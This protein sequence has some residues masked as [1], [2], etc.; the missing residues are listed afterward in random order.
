M[1]EYVVGLEELDESAIARAGGKAAHLGALTRIEGIRVPAGFCVTTEAFRRVAAPAIADGIDRLAQVKPDDR[2]GICALCAEIR[3]TIEGIVLPDELAAALTDALDPDAAYAVRSSATAEDLPTASFAGQQ[4]TFLDVVGPAAVLRHVVRC[5]A[6]LFTERAAT[7]RIQHGFDHRAVQMAVVVQ[8][9]IVPQAAGVLFTADP[10]SGHRKIA[11]V[12]AVF[13]LGEALVSGQARADAWRVRDGAILSRSIAT[14]GAAVGGG[15]AHQP[16]DPARQAEPALTDDQVVQLVELGRRIEAHFGQPQDIEWCLADGA[17]HF[18]Q[19]R[20]ITTLFPVPDAGDGGNHVFVSV[21]HQQM[22]TDPIK[23]LGISCFQLTAGR[24][25]YE[26]GARLFVD[27]T[28]ALASPAGRAGLVAGLGR[29][30]PLIGSALQTFVDRGDFLPT[31]PHAPP[32]VPPAAP[33][34]LE[35]DPTIVAALIEQSETSLATLRLEIAT[36]SGAALVDFVRADLEEL[37]RLMFDPRSLQAIW[38]SVQAAAWLNAQLEA[39]LGEKNAAD[40]L[41]QS[42]PGNVTSE[43][44]LA[45]LDVADAIRPHPAVVDFLRQVEG[46]DFLDR[47]PAVPGGAAASDAIRAW[48]DR[49]GMRCPGEI[50][51]TRPRWSE[52]PAALLPTLLA[53]VASFDPGEAARRFEQGRR[54]AAEK[55]RTLLE[56][57]RAL[58]GGEEKAAE[59][60]RQIDRLRTFAGYREYPKYA[61]ISRYFVYKQAL[62]AE[63]NRLVDAGVL[64]DREEIF[65]L[66][67]P[68][69]QEVARTGRADLALIRQREEAFR[70]HAAL[71]PPRVITS[72]GEVIVG[73][74]E[75]DDCPADALVG[76]AVSAGVVEG[77]ARVVLDMASA[78]LQAGDILVTAWTDPSW[79]PLFVAIEGLVTEVGGLM[80]HGAVIAREYGLPAVVGVENATRLIRDGQRIRLNGTG[81]WV[82]ILSP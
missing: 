77:R 28:G 63:A 19:S 73:A 37:K 1:S 8:R 41:A 16:V 2:A 51:I 33:A 71:T 22:M 57:L 58:P 30:D 15:T 56:R 18:V 47:L 79:T 68:E 17:F 67:L 13:G 27:V 80:T 74:Y 7:Y 61:L 70:S 24:P 78:D 38:A 49:Y 53:H 46:D 25:M 36:R 10:I 6:S 12:E 75:R 52:R 5:W 21:G 43:M 39:W 42:V 9:M 4:D 66:T 23:P 48:L 76:L 81:G 29:S 32:G 26:A 62:L 44:G 72:D 31:L 64:R 3:E 34:P 65:S 55:E 20:A 60:K 14:K 35:T 82:E 45:L 50:D 11:A 40:A 54:D 59:T 69:L